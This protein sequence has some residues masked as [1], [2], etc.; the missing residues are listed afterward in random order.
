MSYSKIMIYCIALLL[1]TLECFGVEGN[2]RGESLTPNLVPAG[3]N[4][5]AAIALTNSITVNTNASFLYYAVEEEG[6]DIVTSG[7]VTLLPNF[8]YASVLSNNQQVFFQPSSYSPGFKVGIGVGINNWNIDAEYTWIENQTNGVFT[9]PASSFG[10]PILASNNWFQSLST[11]NA[12]LSATS[13]A[14]G[15]KVQMNLVHYTHH[16]RAGFG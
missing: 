10:T 5:P 3:Y 8:S 6:R 15:W 16:P 1:S 7:V 14:S 11:N 2:K 12:P 4:A 13:V 9:P